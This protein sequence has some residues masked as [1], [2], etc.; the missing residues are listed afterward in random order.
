MTT[1]SPSKRVGVFRLILSFIVLLVLG[2]GW[3]LLYTGQVRAV[4][5]LSGSMDP[6]IAIGD[7][8]LVSELR[9]EKP[10]YGQVVVLR[11]PDDNG[12]DLVKRVVGVP[13]DLIE[14]REGALYRN[15]QLES[16][17][18]GGDNWHPGVRDFSLKLEDE[19][20]F[21]VGDN[22]AR[23]HDSTEFGPVDSGLIYAYVTYRYSPWSKRGRI[24]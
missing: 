7:R 15:G 22:R 17:P 10:K 11:S 12:P 4:E 23:S 9:G 18:G 5:V 14:L 8:L 20:F 16:P 2:I 19:K 3:T 21:V 13:G 1:T 6:T 24:E